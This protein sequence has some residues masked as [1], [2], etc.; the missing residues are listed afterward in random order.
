MVAK[1]QPFFNCHK[2]IDM[3]DLEKEFKNRFKNQ[4]LPNDNF[5]TEGLW[6][7]IAEELDEQSSDKKPV[8]PFKRILPLSA[9]LIICVAGLSL[10]FSN[11]KEQELATK[12]E[13]T[14]NNKIGSEN[15]SNKKDEE[16]KPGL[17]YTSSVI[18]TDKTNNTDAS[19][20]NKTSTL[21]SD[22]KQSN[23]NTNN[24]SLKNNTFQNSNISSSK[25]NLGSDLKKSSEKIKIIND[26]KAKKPTNNETKNI[27]ENNQQATTKKVKETNTKQTPNNE[28]IEKNKSVKPKQK[29]THQEKIAR[30]EGIERLSISPL[31]PISKET[32]LSVNNNDE[33]SVLNGIITPTNN[34]L[35]SWQ[36]EAF[37]GINKLKLNHDS[38]DPVL[39][40]LKEDTEKG[41]Y[42]QSS[43]L[44]LS[45]VYKKNYLFTSGIEMHNS[46]TQ[47]NYKEGTFG[48][49]PN[50][51]ITIDATLNQVTGKVGSTQITDT[52]AIN[53]QQLTNVLHHNNLRT[54]S[55][56][57]LVGYQKNY[58]RWIFGIRGGVVFNFAT[59]QSGKTFDEELDIITFS[60]GDDLAPFQSFQ[61]GFRAN[62]F[63]GYRLNKKWTATIN[64]S[65]S[66]FQSRQLGT[67]DI[68]LGIQQWNFNVGI[69]YRLFR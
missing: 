60:K 39:K 23:K 34:Q 30:L 49:I 21:V 53:T 7:S 40:S 26:S 57:V 65:W 59:Q 18:N 42:G 5:D 33:P 16:Q 46:W 32:I 31:I 58:H 55:I 10:Y 8:F 25:T 62:P 15:D 12:K 1:R 41:I 19:A 9:L 54:I 67:S 61:I 52:V 51:I 3:K 35:V 38:D 27:L 17:T 47:L 28:S 14:L 24:Q 43:G 13:T 20:T 2:M 11:T 68:N 4:E 36:V 29:P 6:D 44:H 66:S 69:R 64:P 56:P 22:E 37:T 48:V 50:N 45:G 63:I